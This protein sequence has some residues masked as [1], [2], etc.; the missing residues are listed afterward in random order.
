MII[1]VIKD[2]IEILS[3]M[4]LNVYLN[5]IKIFNNLFRIIKNHFIVIKFII[6]LL[7]IY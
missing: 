3:K 7:D 4:V 6:Y 1:F 2:F 5:I